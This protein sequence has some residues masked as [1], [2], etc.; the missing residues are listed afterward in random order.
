MIG[1]TSESLGQLLLEDLR[2]HTITADAANTM[3]STRAVPAPMAIPTNS[4]VLNSFPFRGVP[5]VAP[6]VIGVLL[7]AAPVEPVDVV[8]DPSAPPATF[9]DPADEDGSTK[10]VEN[11]DSKD[12][13]AAVAELTRLVE[14]AELVGNGT[15]AGVD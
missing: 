4:A 12:G 10:E 11:V 2:R 13:T 8:G 1:C 15:T 9:V 3:S 7:T 6:F 14:T 5:F